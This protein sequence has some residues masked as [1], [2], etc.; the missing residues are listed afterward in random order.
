MQR[1]Q[2]DLSLRIDDARSA[3]AQLYATPAMAADGQGA[4]APSLPQTQDERIPPL[5]YA[6]AQLHGI[7][8]LAENG[9]GLIVVDMHAAHERIG[10]EKHKTA[11]D[12]EGL[13]TQPLL[14]PQTVAVSAREAAVETGRT[15]CGEE[16]CQY[17]SI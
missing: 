9:D 12:G 7:Y 11:P 10:Y 16:V 5:G 4:A 13:R 6:V 15:S 17:G 3:Y 14:V 2:S 1:S 8:V